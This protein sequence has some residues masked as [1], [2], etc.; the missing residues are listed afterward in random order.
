[1]HVL[2]ELV[3]SDTLIVVP[4]PLNPAELI[5]LPVLSTQAGGNSQEICIMCKILRRREWRIRKSYKRRNREIK[6]K[7]ENRENFWS[8]IDPDSRDLVPI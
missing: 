1:M 8:R 2:L 5:P 7:N 4:E 3:G 6:A